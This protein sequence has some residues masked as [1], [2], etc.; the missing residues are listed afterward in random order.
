MT[1]R[2]IVLGQA[3]RLNNRPYTIIG[4]AERGFSGTTLFGADF[5]VPMAMDAHV[6]S[7]DRSA[8]TQHGSVWMTAIGRLKPGATPRQARDELQAI[9][10][11]YLTEQGDDRG[12]RLGRRCRS[13]RARARRR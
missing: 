6:R 4:V 13:V 9:M 11:D 10:R 3:I 1:D 7:S 8:L 2:Q 5:W 12:S